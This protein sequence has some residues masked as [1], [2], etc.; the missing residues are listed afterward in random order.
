MLSTAW[1]LYVTI[2]VAALNFL[3]VAVLFFSFDCQC[4]IDQAPNRIA[5]R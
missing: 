5:V 1:S 2:R 3:F 4:E